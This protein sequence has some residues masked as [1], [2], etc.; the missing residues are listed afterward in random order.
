MLSLNILLFN[1]YVKHALDAFLNVKDY[2]NI[3]GILLHL[4][5]P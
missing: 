1:T 5:L 2:V 4:I 3:E